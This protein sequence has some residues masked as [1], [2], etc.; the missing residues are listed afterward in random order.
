MNVAAQWRGPGRLEILITGV[1]PGEAD[2]LL[3]HLGVEPEHLVEAN[4]MVDAVGWS[5]GFTG[6]TFFGPIYH[7]FHAGW[8]VCRRWRSDKATGP[9][10]PVLGDEAQTCDRCAAA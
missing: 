4:R 7:W 9:F 1:Q 6:G 10:L 3:G 5:M 2:A 8:S